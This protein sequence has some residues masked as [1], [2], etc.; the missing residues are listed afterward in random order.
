MRERSIRGSRQHRTLPVARPPVQNEEAVRPS[1]DALI[2]ALPWGVLISD[3]QGGIIQAND[4]AAELLRRSPEELIGQK[5]HD[6]SWWAPVIVDADGRPLQVP[7]AVPGTMHDSGGGMIERMIGV[8]STPD[9]EPTWLA[10]R[11][12]PVMDATG[13]P[14][15]II[16]T[17]A[18]VAEDHGPSRRLWAR[19]GRLRALLDDLPDAYLVLS[20]EGCILEWFGAG[21]AFLS[22]ERQGIIG[23]HI[24]DL[25]RPEYAEP[26]EQAIAEVR[27]GLAATGF[28]FSWRH[29]DE[30]R[31]GEA[32]FRLLPDGLVTML[33][34]DLTERWRAEE[35]LLRL[36]ESYRQMAE[37]AQDVIARL[38]C[39]PVTRLE[40]MSSAVAR[41]IGYPPESFYADPTLFFRVLR[42]DMVP[43]ARRIISG[44][45][46]FEQ[47]WEAC[48]VHRDG[49]HVW[50]ELRMTPLRGGDRRP[51]FIDAV[52]R[53]VSA[54]HAQTERL[55]E[56]E[57]RFRRLAE[58]G[59]DV[60]WRVRSRPV[61][62]LEYVSPAVARQLGHTP[63]ELYAD[64]GLF[65]RLAHEDQRGELRAALAGDYDYNRPLT[66]GFDREDGVT[67]WLQLVMNPVHDDQGRFCGVQGVAR[68]ITAQHLEEESSRRREERL[69]LLAELARDVVWQVRVWP[70]ER[71][72]YVSPSVYGLLGYTDSE[73]LADGGLWQSLLAPESAA[74]VEHMAEEDFDANETLLLR[75]RRRDGAAAFTEVTATR[76][77]DADGRT[78]AVQGVAHDVTER[79]RIETE[80][81]ELRRRLPQA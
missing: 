81:E 75:W 1:E 16:C 42:R 18:P 5:V 37:N 31:F 27:A 58:E 50:I 71:L 39:R 24:A 43:V 70:E 56:A 7:S 25:L 62:E 21:G 12:R 15:H 19:A 76:V 64:P 6:P 72:E 68:D 8:A 60:V 30:E 14:S 63:D 13:V 61:V 10:V 69:R 54:R 26:L 74:L 2:Q 41:V 9:E 57:A 3:A 49:R 38:R 65:I 53:D 52:A 17:L 11:A 35:E 66:I 47:P 36:E 59:T 44:D 29:G 23:T 77:R 51:A 28:D 40:Y 46:D 48:F 20:A 22:K 78:I 32:V 73:L 45:W 33:V 80:L 55:R 67:V 79:V 34:R 4:L